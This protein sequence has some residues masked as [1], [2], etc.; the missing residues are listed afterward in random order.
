MARR[1]RRQWRKLHLAMDPVTSD[2]RAVEFTLS[3]DSDST[4]LPDLLSQ[5]R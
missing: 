3:C 2:I 5:S 4:V 1:V